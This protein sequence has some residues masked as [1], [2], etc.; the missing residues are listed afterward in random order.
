MTDSRRAAEGILAALSGGDPASLRGRLDEARRMEAR[1]A[2]DS[3]E[4][5]R[6][7]LLAAL[8]RGLSL[9]GGACRELH[10]TLLQHLAGGSG[11]LPRTAMASISTRTSRGSRAASTVDRAGALSWK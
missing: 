11:Y 10:L 7:E 3:G 8:A 4:Q 5:E 2:A 1:P 9:S 6:R